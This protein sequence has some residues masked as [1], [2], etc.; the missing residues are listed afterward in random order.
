MAIEPI[1]PELVLVDPELAARA[2]AALAAPALSPAASEA[3]A[4][5]PVSARPEQPP[6]AERHYPAWARI[7]A[8]MWLLVIGILVGGAAIPHA[9]DKPRVIPRDDDVTTTVC[10]PTTPGTTAPLPRAGP[11][12]R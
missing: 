8:A 7:T 3:R 12:P 4:P 6:T 11:G 2:R 5:A 1:S 10:M 9:Q